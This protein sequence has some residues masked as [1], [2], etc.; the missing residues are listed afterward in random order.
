MG[1]LLGSQR[2]RNNM[3]II[4]KWLTEEDA[5]V[6]SSQELRSSVK[7]VLVP[8]IM[9]FGA[10]YLL[11]TLVVVPIFQGIHSNYFDCHVAVSF[12]PSAR[13]PKTLK[14]NP[15]SRGFLE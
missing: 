11:T 7:K 13:K 9:Q 5:E 6:V 1:G 2:L 15:L 4:E 8:A 14:S 12:P 3:A 10:C